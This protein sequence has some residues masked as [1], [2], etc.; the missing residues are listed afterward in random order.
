MKKRF[1]PEG[2]LACL[3]T[4]NPRGFTFAAHIAMQMYN[5]TYILGASCPQFCTDKK[6]GLWGGRCGEEWSYIHLLLVVLL[7]CM[8]ESTS[9]SHRN[10]F[11]K[12]LYLVLNLVLL[13]TFV[14]FQKL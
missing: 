7:E 3:Y 14:F 11:C 5:A 12:C 6:G 1:L 10:F 9:K 2:L 8:E 13:L 4:L